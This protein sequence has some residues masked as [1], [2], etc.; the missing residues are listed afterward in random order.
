MSSI[1]HE[2]PAWFCL[3]NVSVLAE[4]C[5]GVIPCDGSRLTAQPA[6]LCTLRLMKAEPRMYLWSKVVKHRCCERSGPLG[7]R[8]CCSVSCVWSETF[9]LFSEWTAPDLPDES[10]VQ[11]YACWANCS[12]ATSDSLT[13]TPA[14]KVEHTSRNPRVGLDFLSGRPHPDTSETD[15]SAALVPPGRWENWDGSRRSSQ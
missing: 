3:A 4:D 15:I 12:E 7:R 14:A 8:C 6:W 11:P 1:F 10:V 2:L 9:S 13:L 5:L